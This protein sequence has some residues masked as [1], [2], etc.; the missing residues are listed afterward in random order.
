METHSIADGTA[1][2]L[3]GSPAVP[4]GPPLGP[5]VILFPFNRDA[6]AYPVDDASSLDE[7]VYPL[8][9]LAVRLLG[10]FQ[11]PR[12]LVMRQDQS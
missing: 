7:D 2:S 6:A 4:S 1:Y 11:F 3:P 12:L 10:T 8:G 5:T 9:L